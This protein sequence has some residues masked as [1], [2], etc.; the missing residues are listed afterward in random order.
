MNKNN[1]ARNHLCLQR[2]FDSFSSRG[3][4]ANMGKFGSQ[5]IESMKQ[6]V[7]HAGGRKPRRMRVTKV[8]MSDLKA[9]RESLD[10][11][12]RRRATKPA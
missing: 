1:S 11:S 8:V 7:A 4:D 5:L 2:D 9:T 3:E 10:M 12:Q 6:A